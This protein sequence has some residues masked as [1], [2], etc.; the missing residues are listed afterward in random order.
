[1]MV[2]TILNIVLFIN[3]SSLPVGDTI[4]TEGADIGFSC[5]KASLRKSHADSLFH[6]CKTGFKKQ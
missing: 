6:A 2:Y 5:L 3:L 4:V 1:M